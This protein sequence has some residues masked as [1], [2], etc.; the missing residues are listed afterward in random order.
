MLVVASFGNC[1]GRILKEAL[2]LD[3]YI[4]RVSWSFYWRT[5]GDHF[6]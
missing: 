1:L 4:P 2:V 6:T 5:R 3:G